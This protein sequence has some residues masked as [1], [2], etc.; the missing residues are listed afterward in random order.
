MNGFAYTSYKHRRDQEL[1][2]RLS[3]AIFVLKIQAQDQL[4]PYQLDARDADDKRDDLVRFL[5]DLADRVRLLIGAAT[6]D[7]PN[8]I[9]VG[10]ADRFTQV[11]KADVP[12]RLEALCSVRDR[13]EGTWAI[14]DRDFH[15]LDSLQALLEEE[16][17]EGVRGLYAL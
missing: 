14:R 16:A 2:D 10:L 9:F 8:L 7:A 12:D 17:A 6:E 4:I 11:N 15:L 13:L 5:D 1:L 3:N